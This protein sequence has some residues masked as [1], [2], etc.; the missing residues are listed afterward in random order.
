M[1]GERA[2]GAGGVD[3]IARWRAMQAD[4]AATRRDQAPEPADRWARRAKRF[5]RTSRALPGSA[6]LPE[7]IAEHLR[8]SDVVVDVGAGT[9]R[10]V[11]LFARRC[12]RVIAV[13]PSPSMR[14]RLE[15]RVR[16][17]ALSNVEIV[18]AAWPVAGAPEGDVVFSSHV[19]YG[20]EDAA[21]FLLAMTAAARRACALYLGLRA[22]ASALDPLRHYLHGTRVPGRPAA[23][24]AL[25]VL[26]QLGVPACLA[27]IAGS[28]RC[29][30][31]GSSDDDLEDLCHRLRLDPTHAN[32]ERVIEAL[33]AITPPDVLGRRVLGVT[34]PDAVISW[35]TALQR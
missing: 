25:E 27:V 19:L 15:M 30:D 3:W 12:R 29:F 34:G 33:D 35:T 11:A 4:I 9:G 10:H 31:V 21:P 2:T 20:V 32:R 7:A 18:D 14:L 28:E 5:D 23:L 17:E 16:E 26:H 6:V 1:N 22:P 8:E 13:E 24:E